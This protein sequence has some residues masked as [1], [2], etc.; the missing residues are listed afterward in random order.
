M[1]TAGR[2][3]RSVTVMLLFLIPL[4]TVAQQENN[5]V[6][7]LE[8]AQGIE[9][10]RIPY[11]ELTFGDCF[12]LISRYHTQWNWEGNHIYD[13]LLSAAHEPEGFMEGIP[14]PA[15]IVP[16]EYRFDLMVGA[17]QDATTCFSEPITLIVVVRAVGGMVSDTICSGERLTYTPDCIKTGNAV[18]EDYLWQRSAVAGIEEAASSGMGAID[19]VLTNTTYKP[20]EVKYLYTVK[21][22]ACFPEVGLEVSVVVN[23]TITI[24]FENKKVEICDGE[25][26]DIEIKPDVAE[27]TYAWKVGTFGVEGALPGSGKSIHQTLYYSDPPGGVV[28]QITALTVEGGKVCSN[29]LNVPVRV[30]ALPEISLNWVAPVD[31]VTLGNPISIQAYPEY[32][33]KYLFHLNGNR[34]EQRSNELECYD[35]N[36]G[37]ENQVTV[38]VV[39]DEGCKNTDSL[40]FIGPELKLP[41]VITPNG[42]GVNDRLFDGFELEVFNRNGSQLYKGREGWDGIYSGQP[43]PPGTYLYV[44]HYKTPQG[45]RITKKYHVYVSEKK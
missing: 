43:V 25:T 42:D 9:T 21:P 7:R 28:Y 40:I 36:I 12:R 33:D 11:R 2:R 14:V 1:Q 39:S 20:I 41:N 27:I 15:G 44:V 10:L 37:R 6:Y 38:T 24:R 5:A 23:P 31:K 17:T 19:E 22:H 4:F 29:E 34:T 16:G 13:G 45:Q 8:I 35:W 26:T 18:P 3:I 30:K 32:Y